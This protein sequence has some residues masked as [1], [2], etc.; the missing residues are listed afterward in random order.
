MEQ[1]TVQR[2]RGVSVTEFISTIVA[3]AAAALI[4]WK[5]TDVRLASL[6][7][8]ISAQE[9]TNEKV[10]EKLDKIQDGVNSIYVNLQTK[11]DKK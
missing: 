11:Q 9:K 6:E 1:V 3:I 8:R 5:N 2:K 10:F 7:I 4:F